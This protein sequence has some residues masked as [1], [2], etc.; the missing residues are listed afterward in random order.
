MKRKNRKKRIRKMINRECDI[1]LKDMI[2]N[3]FLEQFP[4]GSVRLTPAGIEEKKRFFSDPKNQMILEATKVVR[5][6]NKRQEDL[7]IKSAILTTTRRIVESQ[8]LGCV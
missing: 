7:R 2:D 4:D 6:H 8:Q 5:E 1:V 3:G